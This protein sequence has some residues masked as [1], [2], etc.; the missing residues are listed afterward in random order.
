MPLTE[1]RP[2]NI[3]YRPEVAHQASTDLD[4]GF[5]AAPDILAPKTVGGVGRG[6]VSFYSPVRTGSF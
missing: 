6:S 2:W 4:V 1:A 3:C 5:L